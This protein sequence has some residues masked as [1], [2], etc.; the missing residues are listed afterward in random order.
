MTTNTVSAPAIATPVLDNTRDRPSIRPN[1]T[2]PSPEIPALTGFYGPAR[3]PAYLHPTAPANA[4]PALTRSPLV[5]AEVLKRHHC[6]LATDPRFR[7]CARYLQHLHRTDA[8]LAIGVHLAGNP[9]RPTRIKLGSRLSAD[10]ARAGH[11]FVSPAVHAL[12]RQELILREEGA[13]IDEHRLF[14]NLLSSMPLC[15]NLFGPMALDLTLATAVWRRLLP[16]FV[17]QVESI[18]FE[19]SPGRGDPRLLG[20]GTAFDLH[21]SVITRQGEPASVY[22]EVKYSEGMSGPAAKPRPRYDEASRQCRLYQDPDS[23]ALRSVA[24]EQLRREHVLGQLAVDYRIA[25]KAHFVAIGPRLNRRVAAAF[26]LYGNVLAEPEAEDELRVG[27]S[28]LTLEAVLEA[29]AEAGA[30]DLARQLWARYLDFDRVLE[31]ALA[32]LEQPPT[33]A[34]RLAAASSITKIRKAPRTS[35][36]TIETSTPPDAA[37]EAASFNNETVML[38][39]TGR[40]RL[41]PAVAPKL[42]RTRVHRPSSRRRATGPGRI[43]PST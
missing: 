22:I 42:G 28:P 39:R 40:P 36:T 16:T 43:L 9:E 4:R 20:D 33:R 23:P 41:D 37:A 11:N 6:H 2:S 5:P 12:A 3:R 14:G 30:G 7:A 31:H 10:A 24:L 15:F 26:T 17:H 13:A 18:A 19:H 1:P 21:L 32:P 34:R 8:G 29:V 27:Y 25:N 38:I 35:A